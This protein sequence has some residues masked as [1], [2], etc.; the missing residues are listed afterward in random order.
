MAEIEQAPRPA[1]ISHFERHGAWI[2]PTISFLALLIVWEILVRAFK[3]PVYLLPAPTVVAEKMVSAFPLFLEE[4]LHSV[5]AIVI[6][7]ALAVIVGIP[8]AT[9]MIY[10]QWFRR[11]IYPV[12]L[13][14]Q[15]LPKV[16]L[17]PLFIVWFGFGL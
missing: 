15:V 6:G 14:A 5:V 16:A 8:A 17:A 4:T 2:I 3:V 7:F 12:L 1:S 9:L 11:S 10:S 13:T